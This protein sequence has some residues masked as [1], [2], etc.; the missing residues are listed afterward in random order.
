MLFFK[1]IQMSNAHLAQSIT[2]LKRQIGASYALR[3][4]Y[5]TTNG[6]KKD[7]P[8]LIQRRR[9]YIR[10]CIETVRLMEAQ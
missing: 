7:R 6:H 3:N 8:D 5:L 1:E 9:D 2:D 4:V 10:T